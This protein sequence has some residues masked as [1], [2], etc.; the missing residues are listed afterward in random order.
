MATDK[1]EYL[2]EDRYLT[3]KEKDILLEI[4]LRYSYIFEKVY[5][6]V[7]LEMWLRVLRWKNTLEEAQGWLELI[8]NIIKHI[9]K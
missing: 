3:K 5:R 4:V 7:E 9:K 2:D 1:L 6:T 8:K